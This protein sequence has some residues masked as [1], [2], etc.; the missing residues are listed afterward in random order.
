MPSGLEVVRAGSPEQPEYRLWFRSAVR[1]VGD[2]PLT[3]D[4]HRPDTGTGT[5]VAD[6]VVE[7]EDGPRPDGSGGR[8]VR[9][10]NAARDQ[11][12]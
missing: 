2:G 7:H 5:M 11:V 4:G 6:Q 9:A 10:R 12:G 8:E 1:N 3:I